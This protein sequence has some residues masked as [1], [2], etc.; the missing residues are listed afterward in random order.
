[1]FTGAV[2][3]RKFFTNSA[4]ILLSRIAGL[5]RTTLLAAILGQ[6]IYSDMF[7]V[8]FKLPNMFR[9]IFSEGAFVQAFMPAFVASRHKGVFAVRTFRRFLLL[10]VVASIVVSLFPQPFTRLL[11]IGWSPEQVAQAAPLTAITF[12]YLALIFIVTFFASLLQYREHYA[13]TAF[14]TVLLNLAMIGALLL[15]RRDAPE[16]IAYALAVSVLVGGALQ[17]MLH[18]ISLVR[19]RLHRLLIGGW[20]HRHDRD[21][22]EEERNFNRLFLPA[23]WGNSTPQLNAFIDTW[24]A[25]FLAAGSISALTYGNLVFTLPLALIAIAASTALFPSITK[26]LK[27][28]RHA[29]AWGNLERAFWY[30]AFA[31]LAAAIGGSVLAEPIVWLLFEHGRFTPDDTLV[32][33]DV[34]RMYMVGLLPFGLT[35][36]LSLY[37]YATHRQ[38]KAARIATVSL[39]ANITASLLLIAPLGVRGL[40][41]AGSIGGWVL[42][43]LTVRELGWRGHMRAVIVSK[44]L[45]YWIGFGLLFATAMY[46]LNTFFMQWIRG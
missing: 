20:R 44:R 25:S 21:I 32:T 36:L 9:R 6:S 3:F 14:G 16:T 43:V 12:W 34:L 2:M 39:A 22:S 33:A 11:V 5:V 26:D 27:H 35:K 19:L 8:A 29:Q 38:A 17:V 4:G 41:L 28:D 31:L 13:T 30:M 18:L 1:M 10:I 46:A 7:L 24:L 37:L 42:F 40:A 23:V 15:W 45:G